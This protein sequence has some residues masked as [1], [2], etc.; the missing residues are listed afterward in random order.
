VHELEGIVDGGGGK[1]GRDFLEGKGQEGGA[2]LLAGEGFFREKPAVMPFSIH[3]RQMIQPRMPQKE[4][5]C[6][7]HG[8]VCRQSHP[9]IA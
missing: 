9:P 7:F 5:A 4:P 6:F 8:S 2:W 1:E 3:D